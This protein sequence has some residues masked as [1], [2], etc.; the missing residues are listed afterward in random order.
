MTLNDWINKYG[1]SQVALARR[2][3]VSEGTVSRIRRRIHTPTL[4]IAIR[5]QDVT[6][7]EVGLA[8][9]IKRGRGEA[10]S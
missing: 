6:N 3:G 2:L 8:D 9:L 10:A 5:L 7:N 4:D 1:M